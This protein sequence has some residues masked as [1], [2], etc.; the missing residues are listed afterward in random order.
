MPLTSYK[1]TR[2]KIPWQNK[3]LLLLLISY[4]TITKNNT[5]INDVPFEYMVH[6]SYQRDSLF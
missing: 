6:D 3:F 4:N 2:F 5:M 1:I